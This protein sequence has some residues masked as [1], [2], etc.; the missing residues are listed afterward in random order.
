M[1]VFFFS[2]RRRHTRCSRDWSSDVCSSDLAVP[3]AVDFSTN[4]DLRKDAGVLNPSTIKIG[5]AAAH[6]SG[7]YEN[8]GDTTIVNIKLEGQNM[9]ARDLEAFLPAIAIHIPKGASLQSGTLNANLNIQG[10]TNK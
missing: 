4:Y 2:S 3:A 6:L 8:P 1:S 9:P 10:P 7:T 5:S